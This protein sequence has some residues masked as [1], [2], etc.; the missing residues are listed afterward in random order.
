METFKKRGKYWQAQI[1]RVGHVHQSRSFDSKAEAEAWARHVENE[2]DR[3][4]F[5]DRT[6]AERTTLAEA[7]E[8]NR[9]EI[10]PEK[11]HPAQD[12]Q[13]INRWL[14]YLITKR[15]LAEAA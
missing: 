3:G 4:V 12:H 9:R 13:R 15:S 14:D 8:R 6:E 10:V 11:R 2:M 7:L 5:I 1:R